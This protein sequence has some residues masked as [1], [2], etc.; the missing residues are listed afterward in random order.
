MTATMVSQA[1]ATTLS[2]TQKKPLSLRRL[3]M[4][5]KETR[6]ALFFGIMSAGLYFL[7]YTYNADIRAIGEATNRGDKS[8]FLLPIGLAFVF[9]IFHGLFTD[10]FW[11]AVGLKAKR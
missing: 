3:L 4:L 11:E 5:R 9:S 8:L 10:R 7:L 2:E 1:E 6:A